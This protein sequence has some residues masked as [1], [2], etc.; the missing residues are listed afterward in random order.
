[1]KGGTAPA[2]VAVDPR[3]WSAGGSGTGEFSVEEEI[4]KVQEYQGREF[5]GGSF[6]LGS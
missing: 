5:R 4:P 6:G 2:P 1:M 3:Q